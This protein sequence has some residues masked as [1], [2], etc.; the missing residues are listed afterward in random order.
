MCG[1][2][3]S[4]VIISPLQGEVILL[5]LAEDF[6]LCWRYLTPN[7]VMNLP[8]LKGPDSQGWRRSL[9]L[10]CELNQVLPCRGKIPFTLHDSQLTTAVNCKW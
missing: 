2:E 8:V 6:V 9:H 7:G 3:G 1:I 5:W 4:A 10:T